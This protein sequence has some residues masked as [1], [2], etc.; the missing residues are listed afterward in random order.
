MRDRTVAPVYP[1]TTLPSILGWVFRVA[2]CVMIGL[3]AYV[4]L[5][6]VESLTPTMA[7]LY[8]LVCAMTPVMM[9]EKP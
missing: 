7:A 2:W 9:I 5:E 1:A 8:L 3:F 4:L 6:V